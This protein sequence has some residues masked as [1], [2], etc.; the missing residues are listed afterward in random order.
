MKLGIAGIGWVTPLGSSVDD[1]WSRLLTGDAPQVEQV[2]DPVG[3]KTY[4]VYRVSATALKDLPQHPRLRRA[5]AI[6]RFAAAA[7]LAALREANVLVGNNTP[8]RMALIFAVA[9][10]GVIY[11]K[12]F[13]SDIVNTG[14]DAASPLLFP[15]TVFNA[16][17]SHLAAIIGLAGTTYTLVGDG[18]VGLS[19]IKMAEDLMATN[20]LDHCLVVAAEEADWLLC[21]AYQKWRFLRSAPPLELFSC[22]PKGTILSEGAG[23]VLLS[24]HGAV[25][26]AAT[27]AGNYFTRQ[28]EA[29]QALVQ[30]L[31]QVNA[32]RDGIV[33]GSANGTFIDRAEAEALSQVAPQAA[34]YSPKAALGEG[35]AASSLWQL[36]V[37]VQVLRSGKCPP[38]QYL[39]GSEPPFQTVGSEACQQ[40]TVLSCGLNQQVGAMQLR[41]SI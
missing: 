9:N 4:P 35:V 23:A 20:E 1:V 31:K 32:P 26:I 37:A 5:S 25:T 16:A 3:T 11:T 41:T 22:Y 14:A 19:A 2:R 34:I 8:D 6:S 7:G 21:D 38:P 15:E 29:S 17:A 36:I 13:Y 33:I 40:I 24:R 10:G 30:A 27:A 39:P 18:S 12:R 28:R